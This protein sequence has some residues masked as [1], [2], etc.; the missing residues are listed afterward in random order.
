[1]VMEDRTQERLEELRRMRAVE[2][3]RRREERRAGARARRRGGEVK[4]NSGDA[5]PEDV[6]TPMTER[7][8]M[9]MVT[10]R[11]LE[12]VAAEKRGVG[13]EG[14][15]KGGTDSVRGESL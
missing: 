3:E 10:A 8:Q 9:A 15:D 11:F 4:L 1:L 13:Q 2:L 14:K 6:P 5:Q 7:T 12:L